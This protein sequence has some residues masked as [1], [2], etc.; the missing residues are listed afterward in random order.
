MAIPQIRV[1]DGEFQVSVPEVEPAN[2]N[3]IDSLHV[4]IATGYTLNAQSS[5]WP[6]GVPPKFLVASDQGDE[7]GLI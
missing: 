7:T 6:T 4:L 2:P 5:Q 1:N 3:G